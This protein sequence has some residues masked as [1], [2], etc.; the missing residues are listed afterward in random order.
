VRWGQRA[1]IGGHDPPHPHSFRR[2]SLPLPPHAGGEGPK[3]PETQPR[4]EMCACPSAK[5]GVQRPAERLGPWIPA[6]AGMTREADHR[7]LDAFAGAE[8]VD[9]LLREVAAALGRDPDHCAAAVGHQAAL[10]QPERAGDHPQIEHVVDGDRRFERGVR[11]LRRP[12]AL[13][14]RDHRQLLVRLFSSFPRKR[15]P[16]APG[17]CRSPLGPRLRGGDGPDQV[18]QHWDGEQ[19]GGDLVSN[20]RPVDDPD[21]GPVREVLFGALP[22]DCGCSTR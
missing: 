2:G 4:L 3:A 6:F 1:P 8:Q 18:A 11:V 15:E 10:Q 5:A 22:D 13:H 14:D 20:G 12:F 19:V 9:R 16:R 7:R 21:I 17:P